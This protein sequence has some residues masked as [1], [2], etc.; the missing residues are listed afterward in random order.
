MLKRMFSGRSSSRS[1]PRP[2]IREPDLE[3]PRDAIV[4]ACE[5]SSDAFMIDIGIKEEFDMYIQ[6][7]ELTDFLSDKCPQYHDL[8]DSF[9]RK[10]KYV[11]HRSSHD[12]MFDLYDKSFRMTV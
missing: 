12:V 3:L 8:T 6:N 1:S 7:V 4:K 10:F 5:W 11:S 2:T 9:V